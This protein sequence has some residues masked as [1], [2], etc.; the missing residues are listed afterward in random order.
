MASNSNYVVSVPKLKGR[1]NY[2]EWCFAAENFLVLEGTLGCI[3]AEPGQPVIG[4]AED[5]KTRAKLILTIDP[6][7][8]VHIKEVKTTKELWDKL[9]SLFDDSGFTRR[10]SLLRNLI[11]I[12]LE[13]CISMTAYVTQIVETGQKL[14]A[15]RV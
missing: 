4:A 5:A 13:N 8:Y 6:P 9:K 2:S 15:N 3:K 10:I 12:R 7:I 14:A 1:E 11:S